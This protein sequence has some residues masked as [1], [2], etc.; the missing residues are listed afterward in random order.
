MRLQQRRCLLRRGQQDELPVAAVFIEVEPVVQLVRD[1]GR[2]ARDVD[3]K[4]GQFGLFPGQMPERTVIPFDQRG[5]VDR[6]EVA[7]HEAEADEAVHF[8]GLKRPVVTART[9]PI[10]LAAVDPTKK[11]MTPSSRSNPSN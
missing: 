8:N 10:A 4:V 1:L 11:L 7:E 9:K 3:V 2:I 6:D 5:A